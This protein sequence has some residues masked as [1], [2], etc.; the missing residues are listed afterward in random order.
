ML[1]HIAI[2]TPYVSNLAD[3]YLLLPNSVKKNEFFET[4]D[5]SLRSIWIEFDGFILMIEHGEKKGA[6]ALVFAYNDADDKLWE[7]FLSSI[8]PSHRTDYTVYFHD[9]DGNLLGVS[10]YPTRLRNF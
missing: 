4:I 10:S 8:K 7:I 5:G 2:G 6:K 1:H 9:P 3:F